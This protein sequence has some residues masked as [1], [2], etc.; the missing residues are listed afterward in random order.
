MTLDVA[1]SLERVKRRG[2]VS[3]V[4]RYASVLKAID[5]GNG[6][7]GG[8]VQPYAIAYDDCRRRLRRFDRGFVCHGGYGNVS[9]YGCQGKSVS[10][11][12]NALKGYGFASVEIDG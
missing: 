11:F 2:V 12:Y 7:V 6:L 4:D 1:D 3:A 5:A 8:P 9:R 10:R